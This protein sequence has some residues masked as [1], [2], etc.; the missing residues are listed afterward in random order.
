LPCIVTMRRPRSSFLFFYFISMLIHVICSQLLRDRS[1]ECSSEQITVDLDFA[2]PFSGVVFANKFYQTPDCR[3]EGDGSHHL[4]VVLQLNPNPAKQP[5]CGVEHT[6]TDGEYGITLVLSPMRDLLVEGMEGLTVRCEY[7]MD[8]ITPRTYAD[9]VTGSGGAPLLK[10]VIRD[11]HGVQGSV[12]DAVHVGQRIT[13]DVIMEDTSIYD[14]YVHDCYAHD[15]MNIPEASIGIIDQDGCAIR[16]SRAVDVP[17]FST[18]QA[19]TGAKHVFI[20][21][22]GF[23]FTT[24]QLVYIQCQVRPCLQTCNRPQCQV[25]ISNTTLHLR[26]KRE[27]MPE[28][29]ALAENY[30]LTAVIRIEPQKLQPIMPSNSQELI[31]PNEKKEL[32]VDLTTVILVL[33]VFAIICV[34]SLCITIYLCHRVQVPSKDK[35][36]YYTPSITSSTYSY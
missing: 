27:T 4:K 23:Q 22:Y 6:E 7:N 24:S 12:I 33:I 26:K 11:G 2:H 8:D 16:L 25:N 14:F 18:T 3:W 9:V 20:H 5:Y 36:S 35:F 15:G 19:G 17:T 21:M 10:M 28:S 1:V 31:Q 30:N 29:F 13:L 34:L 32:C